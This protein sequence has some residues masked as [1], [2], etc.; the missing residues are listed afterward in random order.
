MCVC[1]RGASAAGAAA[2][3]YRNGEGS[4]EAPGLGGGGTRSVGESGFDRRAGSS[5]L[6]KSNVFSWPRKPRKPR[7]CPLG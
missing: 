6:A 2:E 3:T 4:G 1:A 5:K 7:S